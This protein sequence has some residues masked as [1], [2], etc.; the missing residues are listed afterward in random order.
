MD[1]VFDG[2]ISSTAADVDGDGD[3]DVLGAANAA[4]DITWWENTA[5]AHYKVNVTDLVG[6]GSLRLD[7][8]DDDSIADLLEN[9][10]GGAGTIN[11]DF[12]VGEAYHVVALHPEVLS[13][14]RMDTN[15]HDGRS[16]ILPG[17]LQHGRHGS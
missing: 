12:A 8:I 1:G 17:H 15:P 5:S 9:P 2:A 11:G 6:Q 14:V 16:R 10:L 4:D 13:I 7:L 3:L